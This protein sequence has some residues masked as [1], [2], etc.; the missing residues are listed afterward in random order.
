M[1][2][3]RYRTVKQF[4]PLSFSESVAHHRI[5]VNSHDFPFLPSQSSFLTKIA[6]GNNS[7]ACYSSNF[8]PFLTKLRSNMLCITW[9]RRS[10]YW[11]LRTSARCISKSPKSQCAVPATTNSHHGSSLASFPIALWSSP[12]LTNPSYFKGLDGIQMRSCVDLEVCS[13]RQKLYP[14]IYVQK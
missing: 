4:S 11:S 12:S 10:V 1:G 5:A 14:L 3:L 2:K 8:A 7:W 6:L 13:F 9:Q